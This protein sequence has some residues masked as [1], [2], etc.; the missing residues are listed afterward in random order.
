MFRSATTKLTLWYLLLA[1]CLSLL[2]SV[3][4][5]HLSTEELSEA[6]NNQYNSYVTKNDHDK[7]NISPPQADVQRHGQHLMNELIWFNLIV[8][9]GASVIGY[10]LARRTLK[11]IQDVHQVQMRFTAQASHEL[12]TPLAA[13][14]ADTEV[15]L[16]DNDLPAKAQQVLRGNMRDIERLEQLTR[17][18]L[19]IARYQ[20][21]PVIKPLVLDLDEIIHVSIK[22]LSRAARAKHIHYTQ[23]IQ[24]IQIMGEQYGLEQLATIVLDNAIKYSHRNGVVIVDLRAD[25]GVA[26]L[27]I[28]DNGIGIPKDDVAH[29]FEHFYRSANVK[30]NT[31]TASGYGLGLPLA[32]EIT[33]VHGGD[34]SIRSDEQ[35]GTSVRITLPRVIHE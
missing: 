33:R 4:V 9:L 18:L 29:V 5:Y 20:N 25:T 34:I 32:Q 31:K 6:L 19:D 2:F 17:H 3:V 28:T 27:T 15:A 14:R 22:Q 8:I 7:D 13:M 24:P 35:R 21:K 30:N 10:L 1:T 11:P 16:M 12:R 26:I 23:N